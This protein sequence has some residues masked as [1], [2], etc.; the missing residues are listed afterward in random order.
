M[1]SEWN[2]STRGGRSNTHMDRQRISTRSRSRCHDASRS[3]ASWT[4]TGT[5]STW[6]MYS[7]RTTSRQRTCRSCCGWRTNGSRGRQAGSKEELGV[8]RDG[9]DGRDAYVYHDQEQSNRYSAES[10][11]FHV[12][13]SPTIIQEQLTAVIRRSSLAENPPVKTEARSQSH[14]KNNALVSWRPDRRSGRRLGRCQWQTG[15]PLTAICRNR[16]P[17]HAVIS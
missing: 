6:T 16:K 2:C 1:S 7:R 8:G 12:E 3:D 9:R 5:R 14:C 11:T 4:T 13:G 17:L 15:K 10:I